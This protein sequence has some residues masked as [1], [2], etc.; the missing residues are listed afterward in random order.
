MRYR[1]KRNLQSAWAELKVVKQGK[2]I[3]DQTC[4]QFEYDDGFKVML[5]LQ[6][7]HVEKRPIWRPMFYWVEWRWLKETGT[8][9]TNLQ[10]LENGDAKCL[11]SFELKVKITDVQ[12]FCKKPSMKR[13]KRL[14]KRG[15]AQRLGRRGFDFTYDLEE[16]DV[17]KP[18]SHS[19]LSDKVRLTAYA[20]SKDRP[21]D[22]YVVSLDGL[23]G[24]WHARNAMGIF[25]R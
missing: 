14:V 17:T 12:A 22:I 20:T 19:Y 8:D 11:L 23:P 13:M 5:H 21:G 6:H 16:L 18:I 15:R 4:L 25:R 1:G 10:I 2:R 3:S 7:I 9:K 24:A